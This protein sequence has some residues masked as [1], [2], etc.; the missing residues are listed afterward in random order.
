[1]HLWEAEEG[2]QRLRIETEM[3][4]VVKQLARQADGTTLLFL[5]VCK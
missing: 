4:E 3:V 5:K 1:L 2:V